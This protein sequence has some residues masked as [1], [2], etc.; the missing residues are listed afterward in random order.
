MDLTL[1]GLSTRLE[2]L[3]FHLAFSSSRVLVSRA[4]FTTDFR[5]RAS[6][7]V[8]DFTSTLVGKINEKRN[9]KPDPTANY[10]VDLYIG[11]LHQAIVS[12]G[13][14]ELPDYA[15]VLK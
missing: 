11:S 2:H 9:R 10:I 4:L 1:L 3:F 5:F 7:L 15:A 8:K 14:D 12:C 6:S 13:D